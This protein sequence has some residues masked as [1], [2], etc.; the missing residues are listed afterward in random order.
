VDK[1]KFQIIEEDFMGNS[2]FRGT[3]LYGIYGEWYEDYE[4][5]GG[6]HFDILFT[7]YREATL[8]L[9]KEGYSVDYDYSGETIFDKQ[10]LVFEKQFEE[11]I[12]VIW[13]Q[14]MEVEK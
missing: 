12:E 6:L 9:L 14:K 11:N 3:E 4:E 7:S 1:V 8:W 10:E 2:I 5:H 13:I